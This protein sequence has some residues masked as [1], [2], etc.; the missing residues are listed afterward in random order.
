MSNGKSSRFVLLGD[1]TAVSES[2]ELL[3]FLLDG[4]LKG[5]LVDGRLK[6]GL[7][8]TINRIINNYYSV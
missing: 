2:I 4:R 1:D 3:S 7:G 8:D 6:G 5:G